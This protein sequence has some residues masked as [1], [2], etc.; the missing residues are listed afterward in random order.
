MIRLRLNA[1]S[2]R[3][4]YTMLLHVDGDNHYSDNKSENGIEVHKYE[5]Q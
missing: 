4:R 2:E 5:G 1:I 3:Y